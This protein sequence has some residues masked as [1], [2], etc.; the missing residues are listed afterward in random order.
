M[1]TKSP[2]PHP[3]PS[4]RTLTFLKNTYQSFSRTS[5]S[6]HAAA[7]TYYA[8]F[9]LFA[10]VAL[11]VSIASLWI[12]EQEAAEWIIRAI[13]P[14]L[15]LD[16]HDTEN[17]VQ[18][19][20]S[21]F[22][23]RGPASFIAVLI[24]I[25]SSARIFKAL[26]HSLNL[27]WGCRTRRW[28]IVPLQYAALL[29]ILAS[30]LFLG[31][32]VPLLLRTLTKYI[33]PSLAIDP[34]TYTWI[35]FAISTLVLFYCLLMFYKLAPRLKVRW[36]TILIPSLATAISLALFQKIFI[37]ITQTIIAPFNPLYGAIGFFMALLYGTYI[38]GVIIILGGCAC[39]VNGGV[40]LTPRSDPHPNP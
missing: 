21:F 31:I 14:V 15:P 32:A 7:F 4:H 8:F 5:G 13:K 6:L 10:L 33:A 9:S 23:G 25:W 30:G 37:W 16:Q 2:S 11:S 36:K 27:A 17:L 19:L 1:P 18:V 24:L 34:S 29:I 38:A 3:S 12:S 20:D 28:W 35:V 22:K 39:A 26:I 40:T